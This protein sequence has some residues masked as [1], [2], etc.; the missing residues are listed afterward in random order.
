MTRKSPYPM[1]ADYPAL[2]ENAKPALRELLEA[3]SYERRIAVLNEC[4]LDVV[5]TVCT[6]MVLGRHSLYLRRKSPSTR[7]TRYLSGGRRTCGRCVSRTRQ[8]TSAISAEKR[9][10]GNIFRGGFSSCV[11]T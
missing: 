7:R 8:A 5:N 9:I 2:I 4:S 10:Y 11:S 3:A 1:R 6:I